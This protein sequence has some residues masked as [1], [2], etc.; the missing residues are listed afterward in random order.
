M[1]KEVKV[2]GR[3]TENVD[4]HLHQSGWSMTKVY[5]YGSKLMFIRYDVQR[6]QSVKVDG[7]K[8]VEADG[9]KVLQ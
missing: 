3:T 5:V 4:G 7:P 9:R 8:I 1:V 2:D 6:N